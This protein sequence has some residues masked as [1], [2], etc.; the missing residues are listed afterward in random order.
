MK[1]RNLLLIFSLIFCV[2]FSFKSFA[3]N[4]Y[5][6][7]E[8]FYNLSEFETAAGA[9]FLESKEFYFY[10]SFG[11][12]DLQMY[13]TYEINSKNEITLFVDKDL[14]N[15]FYIYGTHN[16]KLKDRLELTYARPYDDK[17]EHLFVQI[18]GEKLKTFDFSKDDNSTLTL[19]MPTSRTFKI[20]YVNPE[21]MANIAYEKNL[22]EG[23][24]EIRI[25]HNYYFEMI[26]QISG[27]QWLWK[28]NTLV[29]P[30]HNEGSSEKQEINE[31][32]RAE[33]FE[34]LKA[35]RTEEPLIRNEKVYK[36]I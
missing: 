2:L 27:V 24:N 15:E 16:D 32:T 9:Y 22:P 8:G 4:K 11:N 14:L 12:V 6:E 21:S 7:F 19:K 35:L 1:N 13:G 26:S 29:H 18:Q 28:D 31:E 33:M 5:K 25:F 17:A 34:Y 3:Q 23:I 10:A 20:S 36:R 30:L